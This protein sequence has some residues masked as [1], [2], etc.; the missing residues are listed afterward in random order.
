MVLRH[1]ARGAALALPA[2]EPVAIRHLSVVNVVNGRIQKDVTVLLADGTDRGKTSWR[3]P[4]SYQFLPFEA[5]L[6]SLCCILTKSDKVTETIDSI[7][8]ALFSR[9]STQCEK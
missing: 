7:E 5:V 9:F 4:I 2:P 8:Y 3:I 1:S 6:D